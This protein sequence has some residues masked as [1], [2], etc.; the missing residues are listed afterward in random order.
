MNGVTQKRITVLTR[1]WGTSMGLATLVAPLP[2]SQCL[3]SGRVMLVRG[4]YWVQ[5]SGMWTR[6]PFKAAW[7]SSNPSMTLCSSKVPSF[8]NWLTT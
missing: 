7:A 1:P 8:W 6:Y 4:P 3:N 5:S 2:N